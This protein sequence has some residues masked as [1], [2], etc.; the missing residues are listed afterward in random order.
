MTESA[1]YEKIMW[2]KIETKLEEINMKNLGFDH[3][4]CSGILNIKSEHFTNMPVS[5]Y[6]IF[7]KLF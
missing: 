6:D 4:I 5:V 3:L 1:S 2:E 7:K